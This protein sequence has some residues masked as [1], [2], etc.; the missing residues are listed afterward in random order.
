MKRN[1]LFVLL[2][3]CAMFGFAVP[4]PEGSDARITDVRQS[5][6]KI[7]YVRLKEAT[8]L[9][10]PLGALE[11]VE[12]V[13][14]YESGAIKE[15]QPATP[16][17][18]DS[19]VGILPYTAS[20]ISFYESGAVE[21]MELAKA[22]D[23][24]GSVGRIKVAAKPITFYDNWIPSSVEL[25]EDCQV[26]VKSGVVS[27]RTGYRMF[28][29]ENG[30]IQSFTVS[31]SEPLDSSIGKIYP[32]EGSVMALHPNG[33]LS[34]VSPEDIC[35]VT[36]DDVLYFTKACSP[37]AFR[38]DG[39]VLRFSAEAQ[40]FT[41]GEFKFTLENGSTE[42]FVYEDGSVFFSTPGY[43][44]LAGLEYRRHCNGLFVS[45]A[46]HRLIYWEESYNDTSV[47][48][49]SYDTEGKLNSTS[50][51]MNIL[52]YNQD[53]MRY[54][55]NPPFTFDDDGNV[56][57]YLGFE[58]RRDPETRTTYNHP[59]IVKVAVRQTARVPVE[60]QQPLK[61]EPTIP[62]PEPVRPPLYEK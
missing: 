20:P 2:G 43:V 58:K 52:Q 40:D 1:L 49:Y 7:V 33:M 18:Y 48:S 10:T 16:G 45:P 62:T 22:T 31:K 54:F 13:F 14:F 38:G 4:L 59:V 47:Y 15:F 3:C 37:I 53:T 28:F 44:H 23:V 34:S 8:V 41:F 51:N 11:A 60:I 57:S 46:H 55:E 5:N 36:V 39:R 6:G 61:P 26:K 9:N 56:T 32:Q 29:H 25:A 35:M 24:T 30:T 19:P 50:L 21:E 27:A 12:E 17:D 42:M